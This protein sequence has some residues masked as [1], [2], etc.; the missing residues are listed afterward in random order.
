MVNFNQVI[1]RVFLEKKLKYC[2]NIPG[3]YLKNKPK[4][5][6]GCWVDGYSE[7]ALKIKVHMFAEITAMETLTRTL[8]IV[9]LTKHIFYE[10]LTDAKV[11]K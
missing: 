7:N 5:Q 11:E 6:Y 2:E 4:I 9:C 8:Y 1:F 10:I 3:I